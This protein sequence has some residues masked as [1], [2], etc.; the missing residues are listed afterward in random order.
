MPSHPSSGVYAEENAFAICPAVRWPPWLH[1]IRTRGTPLV[2]DENKTFSW[3]QRALE[4][5]YSLR[6]WARALA[7]RLTIMTGQIPWGSGETCNCTLAQEVLVSW[8]G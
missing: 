7:S 6:V 5:S 4:L 3:L 8:R 2:L 1:M